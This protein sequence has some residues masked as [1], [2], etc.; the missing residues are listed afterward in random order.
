MALQHVKEAFADIYSSSINIEVI[1][2]AF[3]YERYF[4]HL[5]HFI[6]VFKCIVLM[7]VTWVLL[8]VF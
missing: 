7:K 4:K 1:E 6:Y 8:F 5:K 2:T 3:F